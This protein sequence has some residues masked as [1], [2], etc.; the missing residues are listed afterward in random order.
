MSPFSSRFFLAGSARCRLARLADGP[1]ALFLSF[2]MR[3]VPFALLTLALAAPAANADPLLDSAAPMR[4][5]ADLMPEAGKPPATPAYFDVADTARAFLHAGQYKRALYALAD[6]DEPVLRAEILAKLGRFDEAAA[7]LAGDDD[8]A[9]RFALADLKFDAAD[10]AAARALFEKNVA[11]AGN[12]TLADRYW[13]GR[14]CEAVGDLDAAKA[15]YGWFVEKRFLQAWAEDPDGRVFESAADVTVIAAALDRYA[16]LAAEYK[17]DPSLHN[18]ILG[19]FVRAYDVTDRDYWP[20]HLA[21]ARFA[22]ARGDRKMTEEELKAVFA[23]NPNDADALALI[24]QLNLDR[25]D[26]AK[27]VGGGDG[28]AGRRPRQPGG[29]PARRRDAAAATPAGKGPAVRRP[30]AFGAA[31]RLGNARPEGRDGGGGFP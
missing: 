27:A 20:A 1:A 16:T 25:W 29:G 18:T 12:A 15:A 5:R 6:R 28:A 10:F 13:L 9:A 19:M 3:A 30:P 11:D 21:A 14:A 17:V 22:Y 24:G 23:A 31:G 2:A 4:W 7:L 26:F 8:P